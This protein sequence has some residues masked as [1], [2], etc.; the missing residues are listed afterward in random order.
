MPSPIPDYSRAETRAVAVFGW[1]RTVPGTAQW[2]QAEEVGRLA[3]E[4]GFTVYT[5]GY[6]GSM[7]ATSKGAREARDA[8]A[9]AAAKGPAAAI[10]VVGVVVSEL[11]PDRFTEGNRY[12]TKIMDSTSMLHRIEQL[13]THSRYF[14]ILP[15]TTG[16]L[17]ELVTIWVQ[18]NIHPS[19]RPAPVIVAFRDPWEKCCAGIAQTLQ[20]TP[21]QANVI[22]FVDTP[23]EAIA[24]LSRDATG[25]ID[26][27][28]APSAVAGV[29]SGAAV[30]S[31]SL[32]S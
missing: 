30:P 7:E 8:A 9:A 20:L 26:G 23:E 19:D 16:T 31:A 21:Q 6:G 13:T 2:Q 25:E 15:G 11:F 18:K 12:L 4:H 14:V 29:A 28:V 5:G 22:H 3:A 27:S 24:W 1:S 10:E 32:S 17:Q